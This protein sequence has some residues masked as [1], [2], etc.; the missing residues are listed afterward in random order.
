MWVNQ[1][2][3]LPALMDDLSFSCAACITG[4]IVSRLTLSF[5]AAR[6]CLVLVR[7]IALCLTFAGLKNAKKI[8][9]VM[10]AEGNPFEKM[11]I[12][13]RERLGILL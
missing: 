2:T 7:Y 12:F 6:A 10:Q 5:P 8:T 1:D 11:A 4:A 13:F 3:L 9:P